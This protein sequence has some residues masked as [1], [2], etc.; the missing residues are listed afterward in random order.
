MKFILRTPELRRRAMEAIR[1]IPL[2]EV[3]ECDLR[4]WKSTRS[5]E[6]NALYWVRL[7]EISEQLFPDGKTYGPEVYHEYLKGRFLGKIQIPLGDDESDVFVSESTTKLKVSDFADYLTQ[8]E[9]WG[10]EHGVHFS[11][12]REG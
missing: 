5:Q 8:V 12:T 11:D 7:T 9:A 2:N 4:P 1:A 3:W 6:Q 10:A